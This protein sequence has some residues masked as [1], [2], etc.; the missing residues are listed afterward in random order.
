MVRSLGDITPGEK[1]SRA[2]ES[3]ARVIGECGVGLDG[4][5]SQVSEWGCDGTSRVALGRSG[6]L[7]GTIAPVG[8]VSGLAVATVL[9]NVPWDICESAWRELM[10]MQFSL[11][12]G[13]LRG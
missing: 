7:G 4:S 13:G 9:G 5:L 12:I 1:Q 8:G 10:Q 2:S 11:L 6:W 3:D